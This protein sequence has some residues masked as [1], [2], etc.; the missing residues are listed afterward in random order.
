MFGGQTL[1]SR[2]LLARLLERARPACNGRMLITYQ[3]REDNQAFEPNDR[4]SATLYQLLLGVRE[5]S[6]VA[7]VREEGERSCTGSLRSIGDFDV[8]AIA[9]MFG[10]GGHTRAAGFYI[11]RSYSE[12][13][14][15]LI[16]AI[17]ER[18]AAFPSK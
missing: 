15:Q 8:A 7:F 1:N 18:F 5:C 6:V 12:V 17:E 2:Y 9:Q 3:T 10:G 16:A 11:E 14:A 4:D 13:Y